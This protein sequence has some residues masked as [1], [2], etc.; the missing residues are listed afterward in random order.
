MG[1]VAPVDEV[2]CAAPD[3]L[4]PFAGADDGGVLVGAEVEIYYRRGGVFSSFVEHARKGEPC[5]VVGT[6]HVL[7]PLIH[8][9]DLAQLYALVLE[10]GKAGQ[11]YN[12]A[13]VTGAP[14]GTLALA[15]ARHWAGAHGEIRIISADEA[16]RLRGEWARGYAIDQSMSGDKARREL[17]WR[18]VHT[19]PI[20]DLFSSVAVSPTVP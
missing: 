5:P 1:Y 20:A 18:P 17:G 9:D 11:A 7:W 15:I 14:V 6:A 8:A 3:Y 2:N 13:A 12:G 19:N 4:E 10:H 16:A